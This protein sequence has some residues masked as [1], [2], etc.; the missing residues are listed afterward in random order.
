MLVN[1]ILNYDDGVF[2]GELASS[3]DLLSIYK[4]ERMICVL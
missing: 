2:S 1:V 3:L 4:A